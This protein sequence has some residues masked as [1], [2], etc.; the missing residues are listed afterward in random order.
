MARSSLRPIARSA[1]MRSEVY[2]LLRRA[3]VSGELRDG[4]PLVSTDL[5]SQLG[6]SRTP[7]R[8][9][10]IGLVQD[11][12]A[13]ETATG[14][15]IVR[16]VTRDELESFFE[17]RAE[18]E[19]LA[20]PKATERRTEASLARLREIEQRV[21]DAVVSGLS[22]VRPV[23]LNEEFHRALY[24]SSGNPLL[25]RVVLDLGAMT[26]RRLFDRLYEQADAERSVRE[27]RAIVAAIEAGDAEGAAAATSAHVEQLGCDLIAIFDRDSSSKHE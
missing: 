24:E 22:P 8:E 23:E 14:Q 17:I 25:G 6:L 2:E 16:P 11:G 19:R 15:A 13:V 18:L 10:I 3:I 7:V 12:L 4:S 26:A 9:A 27:H 21:A 20:A 1:S 5:A